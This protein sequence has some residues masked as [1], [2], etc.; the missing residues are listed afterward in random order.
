MLKDY[1]AASPQL[2]SQIL[3]TLLTREDWTLRLLQAI[4]QSNV[5]AG[6]LDAA[7]RNAMI[8]HDAEA[9]RELS[10]KLLGSAGNPDRQAV[11]DSYSDVL[12]MPGNT[13]RGARL[14]EMRCSSCHKLGEVGRDVG[15]PLAALQNK[16]SEFLLTAILDPN[17][18]MEAKYAAYSA[19]T[20]DG[21]VYS[22]MI[23]EE[24]AT[25]LT[26]ALA[27]GK[28]ETLLRVDLDELAS[29]GK[30][31]MPE[32]LEKDLSIEQVAD[33]IAFVQSRQ[34]HRTAED[35]VRYSTCR[36]RRIPVRPDRQVQTDS[37]SGV[38]GRDPEAKVWPQPQ[39]FFRTCCNDLHLGQT[40]CQALMPLA[41]FTSSSAFASRLRRLMRFSSACR[42]AH[43]GWIPATGIADL[44]TNRDTDRASGER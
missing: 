18:A 21:R 3:S 2:R 14:F 44:A 39:T 12:D 15:A 7:T 36:I 32:G 23:I 24:T 19:L 8:E 16:T 10:A 27:D 5:S 30:S 25:S 37:P 28:R 38:G 33:V 40:L 20:V 17:R 34:P 22:G 6:E 35:S 9:V 31:F 4:E 11:I 29:G 42:T 1:P 26:L 43:C 13:D 41:G